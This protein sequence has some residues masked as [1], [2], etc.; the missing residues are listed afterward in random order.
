MRSCHWREINLHL[1]QALGRSVQV[2]SHRLGQ[3]WAQYSGQSN[4]KYTW[5]EQIC[6]EYVKASLGLQAK[7]MPMLVSRCEIVLNKFCMWWG[8]FVG[9]HRITSTARHAQR[10]LTGHAYKCHHFSPG[11]KKT[12]HYHWCT[13][14][15]RP[16][17]TSALAWDSERSN[18]NRT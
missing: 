9:K 13:H 2:W 14:L 6:L 3:H 8:C 18:W 1:H 17:C 7:Q 5:Y 15:L 12:S 10:K 11:Q 4:R 16:S